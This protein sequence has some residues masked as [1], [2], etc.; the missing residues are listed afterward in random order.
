M[1]TVDSVRTMPTGGELCDGW[2]AMKEDKRKEPVIEAADGDKSESSNGQLFS[3]SAA[4]IA[5]TINIRLNKRQIPLEDLKK[6]KEQ[7]VG[8]KGRNTPQYVEMLLRSN[9]E[10]D[11]EEAFRICEEMKDSDEKFF[12]KTYLLMIRSGVGPAVDDDIFASES[13]KVFSGSSNQIIES[14]LSLSEQVY[15]RKNAILYQ[16]HDSLS[17]VCDSIINNVKADFYVASPDIGDPLY[18]FVKKVGI[19]E[20]SSLGNPNL[21]VM[22]S[23]FVPEELRGYPYMLYRDA[24]G[25]PDSLYMKADTGS[26]PVSVLSDPGWLK[27]YNSAGGRKPLVD[28]KSCLS[29]RGMIPAIRGSSKIESPIDRYQASLAIGK[30]IHDQVSRD[31]G[32]YLMDI[33]TPLGDNV[34][35]LCRNRNSGKERGIIISKRHKDVIRLFEYEGSLVMR[36]QMK[37]CLC[38]YLGY[39]M[40]YVDPFCISAGRSYFPGRNRSKASLSLPLGDNRRDWYMYSSELTASYK[41]RYDE[42]YFDIRLLKESE[43]Y[44]NSVILN[45][46]GRSFS[47]FNRTY[48]N[49]IW[50][51]MCE[52]AKEFNDAGLDVYTNAMKDQESI[53]GT[54]KLDCP[55][56]ELAH[57]A[58]L[59]RGV[60]TTFSGVMEFLMIV[61][62]KLI[63]L[64]PEKERTRKD[65]SR[66]C[67]GTDYHEFIL[68]EDGVIENS[69]KTILSDYTAPEPVCRDSEVEFEELDVPYV[70]MQAL[71]HASHLIDGITDMLMEEA[72]AGSL[73]ELDDPGC[74]ESE[75]VDSV[76][77]W[78]RGH[79]KKSY[80]IMERNLDT[81]NC[82]IRNKWFEI[83]N[84]SE[85]K[86]YQKESWKFVTDHPGMSEKAIERIARA[87]IDGVG[88]E[89]DEGSGIQWLR[90]ASGQGVMWAK[91]D[92]FDILWKRKD[93]ELY[94]EAASI[95][96]ELADTGEPKGLIRMGRVLRSG[97]GAKK[98]LAK[99]A[100]CFRGAV[101]GGLNTAR[102]DLFDTLWEIGTQ[103]ASEEAVAVIRD[104]NSD[105]NLNVMVRMA[106]AYHEGK[107]VEK[108]QDEAVRILEKA[109]AKGSKVASA[110]L[111][112]IR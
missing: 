72:E 34:R 75:F 101:K 14:S 80:E 28:V 92:L 74:V 57:V 66:F 96:E 106:K 94:G 112:K 37:M 36:D 29:D 95:A 17:L 18:P 45:P 4:E 98:D 97:K 43:K 32:R 76:I 83:L 58:R 64:T 99:A 56:Y 100:E 16:G 65:M 68:Y 40:D 63:V 86:K 84:G 88:T 24:V 35:N 13:K 3:G 111:E 105:G 49:D 78:N 19:S 48:A 93:P 67:D 110:M 21:W 8:I 102:F 82:W 85:F 51:T 70:F 62:C 1:E 69:V 109:V 90:R 81:D 53:P 6:A 41:V 27:E 7:W 89:T 54:M 55:L 10:S 39:E 107:G 91:Y 25:N 38:D 42:P 61:R 73:K 12:L 9:D 31:G 2:S 20:L 87:Y 33:Y 103:E 30:E 26:E 108:D 71:K 22:S 23:D 5:R 77:L 59:C 46:Y 15:S 47:A 11:Y 52:L 104:M 60:I 44:R 50:N 79:T